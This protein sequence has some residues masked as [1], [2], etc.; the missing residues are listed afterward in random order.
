MYRPTQFVR[1][2]RAAARTRA[3][4][5]GGIASGAML[6][7]FLVAVPATSAAADPL[8][9]EVIDSWAATGTATWPGAPEASAERPALVRAPNG[10][11]L[12]TFNTSGDSMPGGELQM[13]RSVDNG[14]TWS[15]ATVIATP[16]LY[17]P[18]GSVASTRGMT[19]LST[20]TILLPFNQGVV[21]TAFTNTESTLYIARST[22][23]GVTWSNVYVPVN[24]PTLRRVTWSDGGNIMELPNGD[25]LLGVYGEKALVPEWQKDPMRWGAGVLRS[26]DGG[27]TWSSF[28][29]FAFDPNNPP[30]DPSYPGGA[31]EFALWQLPDG[32]IMAQIRFAEGIGAV[33]AQTYLSYSGDGGATWTAPVA[34]GHS[35]EA[36]A[37]DAEYCPAVPGRHVLVMGHREVTP[38]GV[39][40]GRALLATS[41]DNGVTW[42]QTDEFQDETGSTTGLGGSTGEPDFIAIGGDRWLALF[43]VQ[44]PGTS[45]FKIVANLIDMHSPDCAARFAAADADHAAAP[46]V[47]VQRA[48]RGLWAW[49]YA[50]RP[51]IAS[52]TTTVSDF[53]DEVAHA[54]NC[55]PSATMR[56]ALAGSPTTYLSP[57]ATLASAGVGH[58]SIV[59]IDDA[60]PGPNP[61]R[62]GFMPK[63]VFPDQRDLGNWDS[64]CGTAPIAVD[65]D[66]TS[67]GLDIDYP[68]G[69]SS[70]DAVELVNRWGTTRLTGGD[71][72]V[73]QSDDNESFTQVSGWT[74][75]THLEAGKLVHRFDGLGI[76]ERYVKINQPYGDT[77]YTFVLD[78]PRADVRAE[79]AP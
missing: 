22:D 52:P 45:R 70:L 16:T 58:G 73:W 47:F 75:S 1:R 77:A 26:T 74:F 59:Q 33:R 78:Q 63:D 51:V 44:V 20:G 18:S 36:L 32:R 2:R 37:I 12:A 67:L 19:T 39:R 56:L 15:S 9:P 10:D 38:G 35:A 42:Q 14:T 31:N 8:G 61:F 57:S 21:H 43:Q 25:L 29:E 50:S 79:F 28:V 3:R 40:T 6:L 7:A 17:G 41:Y 34:T 11:L 4:F 30:P 69:S 71:Y 62:I 53:I 64:A 46:L 49:P 27:L 48:D 76:T 55:E 60:D 68:S 72:T 54:L 13:I 5:S 24:L 65:S 66:A 23:S